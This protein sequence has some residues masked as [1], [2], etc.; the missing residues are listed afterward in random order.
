MKNYLGFIIVF[1]IISFFA[2]VF[3]LCGYA[4]RGAET[5]CTENTFPFM[6][7]NKSLASPKDR[8][9]YKQIHVYDDEVVLDIKN[10]SWAVYLD[11]K[12][13]LPLIS[14]TANGLYLT[15]THPTDIQIG[16]IVSY[17]D[18][19]DVNVGH[20]V[21]NILYEDDELLYITKGDNNPYVDPK[22]VS[23]EQIDRVLIGIIY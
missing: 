17:D 20:R 12:S 14:H 22:P 5:H 18:G 16:D 6:P 1:L 4:Y 13:M 3:F 15:P 23:F 19:S 9:S 11:S 2:T 8:I 7:G 10:V 21:I